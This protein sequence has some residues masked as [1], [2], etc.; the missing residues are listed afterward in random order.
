MKVVP[1]PRG[2]RVP[3]T[4][5]F[6]FGDAV[7][8]CLAGALALAALWAGIASAASLALVAAA[9]PDA[10]IV[11]VAFGW[12]APAPLHASEASSVAW[13]IETDLLN[14]HARRGRSLDAGDIVALGVTPNLRFEWQHADALPYAEIGVGAHLLSHTALR[15]GPRFGTAF[16]F[17][18][19]L[20]VGLRF[21]AGREFELGL[22]VE[23]LSNA[24]IK[25]PNDGLTFGALRFGW[26]F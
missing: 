22:R 4:P 15:G 10:S 5:T 21:G 12:D 17:G 19:W 20:G 9:P 23:H 8:G 24:D 1:A 26:R 25:L 16:Q 14:I 2:R 3:W 13:G 6:G 18:E 7:R 11:G